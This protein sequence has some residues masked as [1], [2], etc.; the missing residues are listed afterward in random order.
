[1]MAA[2]SAPGFSRELSNADLA[3]YL[4]RRYSSN[5]HKFVLPHVTGDLLGE[6]GLCEGLPWA[7]RF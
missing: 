6:H 1:M 7:W 4:Q 5:L 3:L 2:G